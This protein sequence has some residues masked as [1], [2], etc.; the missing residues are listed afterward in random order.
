MNETE[1]CPLNDLI[2]EEVV[3]NTTVASPAVIA[4][5]PYISEAGTWMVYDNASQRYID[6]GILA[7]GSPEDPT[8]VKSPTIRKIEVMTQ[9]EFDAVEN[10][11]D[12]T[13]RIII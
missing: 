7:G 4:P 6:T 9:E 10:K 1:L 13:I 11:T 12:D 3:L 5:A 2:I 8:A